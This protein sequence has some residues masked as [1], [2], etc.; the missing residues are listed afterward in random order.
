MW[1]DP[2]RHPLPS[3]CS[4]VNIKNLPS[5]RQDWLKNKYTKLVSVWD[6]YDPVKKQDK[7]ERVVL[8]PKDGPR[9]KFKTG[10]EYHCSPDSS[11]LETAILFVMLTWLDHVVPR[12]VAQHYLWMH[13]WRC[14]GKR[15]AFESVDWGKQMVLL[16]VAG[17]LSIHWEPK[18]NQKVEEQEICSLSACKLKQD[19]LLFW[20]G[21]Y[22]ISPLVLQTTLPVLLGIQ[23]ADDRSWDM[24]A[25][26]IM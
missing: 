25:S 1:C 3:P 15:L 20:T 5:S 2:W 23:L 9:H 7:T 18:Q 21:I 8:W 16:R 17:H 13:L 10:R 19:I 24:S 26:I 14:F 11:S 12:Y 22:T 6:I 4:T